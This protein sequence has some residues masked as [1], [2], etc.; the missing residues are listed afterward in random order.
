[1]EK[2]LFVCTA[3]I[4]RSPIA[5]GIFN[6]LVED[7]GLNF[8]YEIGLPEHGLVYLARPMSVDV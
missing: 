2:V 7:R 1:M 8:Q 6:A 4:C 3:N 5:V